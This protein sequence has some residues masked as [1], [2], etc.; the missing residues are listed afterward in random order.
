MRSWPR[1][2]DAGDLAFK[3][4]LGSI[5][6]IL[7]AAFAA[8]PESAMYFFYHLIDPQTEL[9]KAFIMILFWVTGA[10]ACIAFAVAAF[11]F[12]GAGLVVLAES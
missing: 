7:C 2:N 8:I 3:F 10:G 5:W 1:R 11:M 9:M 6:T 12:W 4:V